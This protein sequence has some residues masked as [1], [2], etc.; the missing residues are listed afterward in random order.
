MIQLNPD[1]Y[2]QILLYIISCSKIHHIVEVK[3]SANAILC[4]QKPYFHPCM[5]FQR[6]KSC[7][8]LK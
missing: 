1:E 2:Y 3:C 4:C 7:V 6:K 8:I 5:L